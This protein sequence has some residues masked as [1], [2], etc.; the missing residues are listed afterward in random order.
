MRKKNIKSKRPKGSQV[1]ISQ[2]PPSRTK[3]YNYADGT[4]YNAPSSRSRLKAKS[5][6]GEVVGQARPMPRRRKAKKKKAKFFVGRLMF[7]IGFII[8]VIYVISIVLETTQKPV[9][10]YQTVQVGIIDNSDVFDGIIVRNEELVHNTQEGNMYLIAGE[11]DK[12]KKNGQIYQIFDPSEARILEQDI[13]RVESD[14]EKVQAKRQDVSYFQNEIKMINN[15]IDNNM[16]IYYMQSKAGNL[17]HT[18]ELKKQ[19]EFEIVKRKKIH[20]KDDAA[21]LNVLKDEKVNLATQ[22]T[23]NETIYKAQEPGIIS[24]Y[25]D[26][27]EDIF[28][29]DKIDAITEKD[30]KEKYTAK[31]TIANQIIGVSEP[32][33]RI[34]K[35]S[36]WRVVC[37]MPESWAERFKPGQKYDFVLTEDRNI[38]FTLKVEENIAQDKNH[39]IV[40]ASNEQLDA[41]A[42]TRTISFKSLQYQY[43]GLK[44]PKSAITERNLIKIPSE[45]I[46]SSENGK[47]VMK[48]AG[49]AGESVF[50]NLDVNHEDEMGYS[51]ILQNFGHK[52]GLKLG[53]VISHP[54]KADELYTIAEVST[55]KGVYVVNG[56][57]T[58][59]KPV[60]SIAQNDE[61]LIVTSNS[62][63][64]LKQFDQIITNPKNIQ[65]EQ[66]LR[67]MDVQ[68]N[69]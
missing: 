63:N 69:K 54:S 22:L 11:G 64:S 65:E 15:T 19:L 37:F 33:Y 8:G 21:P 68:N 51:H 16:E 61:H 42:N 25:T 38:E 58:R 35:D 18:H 30:L 46:V 40:F 1:P 2:R 49:L 43:Q 36:S 9:I 48:S 47:G 27:F 26:G 44:I 10:S 17:Q 45:Y 62:N 59:F 57:I 4:Y 29:V 60:T 20:M 53:D 14:I 5:G 34:I 23:G 66:L 41:F 24:Y 39:K 28:T 50:L 13:Q 56:R 55:V 6:T 31:S 52:E 12:V 67:N 32:A 7:L 3:H